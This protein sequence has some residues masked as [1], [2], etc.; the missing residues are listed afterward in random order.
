[1]SRSEQ[2]RRQLHFERARRR[3]KAMHP[4]RKFALDHG[5]VYVAPEAIRPRLPSDEEA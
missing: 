5:A 4:A 1:V 3:W 2:R